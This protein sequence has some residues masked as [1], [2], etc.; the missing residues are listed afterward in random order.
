[1]LHYEVVK[2]SAKSNA[3]ECDVATLVCLHGFLESSGMWS[4]LNLDSFA[5][6]IL[7]DLPGHGKSDLESIQS[8]QF[9]AEA[10]F[11]V[12]QKESIDSYK[13]LGHSMGGYVGLELQQLDNHCKEV[14]LMNSNVWTDSKQKVADRKRVAKLVKTRKDRFVSEAIPNLFQVPEQFEAEV[15]SLVEEAKSMCVEAIAEASIAMSHR[16]D[17]TDEVYSGAIPV[18]IIQGEND[19]IAPIHQM[20]KIMVNFPERF[21][22][23][24][25]G[26]MAHFEAAESVKEILSKILTA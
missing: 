2:C 18:Q 17:F 12:L 10:V 26:H 13:V 11:E 1:M 16:R 3:A 7:I 9:M 4:V 8:I 25:S 23:V 5:D 14:I 6:V 22:V 19:P 20:E 21:H 15:K 24:E